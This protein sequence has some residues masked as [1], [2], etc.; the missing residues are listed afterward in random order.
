M[1]R[2]LLRKVFKPSSKEPELEPEKTIDDVRADA[3][4][5]ADELTP[6]HSDRAASIGAFH[7]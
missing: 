2:D 7:P 1:I 4:D 5:K 6:G 3:H